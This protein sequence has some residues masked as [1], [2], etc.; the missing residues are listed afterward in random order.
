MKNFIT[1]EG[2]E[3][4]GKTTQLRFLKEYCE[5]NGID[6]VFTREPGGSEIAEKIR[7]IILDGSNEGMTGE[8]E[9]LLYA[10]AR[11]QH[12]NEVV[13][14]ALKRGSI[15]FCDRFTDST[16]AY[17]GS[18]RGLGGKYVE[19]LNKLSAGDCLPAYTVF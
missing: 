1:F 17:Q 8:C 18:A 9:A 6:A 3:G 15:V 19:T 10:A 7:K 2:C 4:V 5:S 12:I 13:L 16:Y 11:N 14:P